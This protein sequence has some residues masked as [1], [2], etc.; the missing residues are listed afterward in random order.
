MIG[1]F[2]ALAAM[3]AVIGNAGDGSTPIHTPMPA[4]LPARLTD[5]VAEIQWPNWT[6]PVGEGMVRA[7]VDRAISEGGAEGGSRIVIISA[8]EV[9]RHGAKPVAEAMTRLGIT[10][11]VDGE[12]IIR[13]RLQ[14]ALDTPSGDNALSMTVRDPSGSIAACVVAIPDDW[15]RARIVTLLSSLRAD[16][17]R[18]D[19]G[20]VEDWRGVVALHEI[21]H[22]HGERVTNLDDAAREEVRADHF[23]VT[24]LP[25]DSPVRAN[26]VH[27]RTLTSIVAVVNRYGGA[28]THSTSSWRG[29]DLSGYAALVR[30]GNAI[31][32]R[33]GAGAIDDP[34]G[35]PLT[36]VVDNKDIAKAAKGLEAAFRASGDTEAAD[37][38]SRYYDGLARLSTIRAA[39]N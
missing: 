37:L 26:I 16:Q 2:V 24:R 18:S 38:L 34:N 19:I 1:I 39:M 6:P 32:K 11:G 14:A 20:S 17:Q 4:P 29:D 3:V 12:Q 31:R 21:G 5:S 35:K 33:L 22:C 9:A 25:A 10:V 27:A 13:D 7:L 15:E 23:A 8:A 28:A 30:V 36:R